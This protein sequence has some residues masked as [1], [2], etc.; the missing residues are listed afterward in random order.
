MKN[1]VSICFCGSSEDFVFNKENII[2]CILPW[3]MQDKSN[4]DYV[5]VMF[6]TLWR[7]CNLTAF[8]HSSTGPPVCFLSWGTWVQSPRGYLGVLM[9]NRNSPIS[10]VSLHRW[11]RHDWSLWPHLRR[12]SSRTIT[13]PSC[14]QCD[15]PT[16]SHTA[17]LSRFHAHCRSYFWQG[18]QGYCVLYKGCNLS[19]SP[20]WKEQARHYDSTSLLL[21]T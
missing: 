18:V 11:L 4:I 7:A 3:L 12:A 5:T 10:V 8:T 17:F 9:W 13:K 16:W 2:Q 15:N 6:T 19:G 1:Y 21:N 14:R 20:L